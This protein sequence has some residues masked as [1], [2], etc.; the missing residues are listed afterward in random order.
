MGILER[1]LREKEQRHHYII[2]AAEKIFFSKGIS[3]AT[4]DDIA[5][6]AELSKGTLYLYFKNK[7]ELYFA[8]HLRGLRILAEMFE[9]ALHSTQTGILKIRAIGQAYYQFSLEYP[10]YF[11][12]LI[13]YESHEVDI[14]DQNSIAVECHLMGQQ[15]LNYVI[16]ALKSGILDGSIRFGIDPVKTAIILWG[17]SSGL[18]QLLALKGEHVVGSLG[19]SNETIVQYAFDLIMESLKRK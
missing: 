17:Q 13:Y 16:E 18:I 5:A 8:I 6:T 19:I 14:E 9:K 7:E 4:M 10:N 3:A 11:N 12:A 1:K 15:T 2:D